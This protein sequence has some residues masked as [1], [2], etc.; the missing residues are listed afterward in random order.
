[1]VAVKYAMVDR[2][3]LA[4]R[5]LWVLAAGD[6]AAFVLFATLGHA[7]HGESTG[8]GHIVGTA[9]P[10]MVGWLVM[11]PWAGAYRLPSRL[12]LRQLLQCTG[13]AWLCAWPV[14]LLLRALILQRGIPLSFAL[15]ALI[16]NAVFLCIWRTAFVL[17]LSRKG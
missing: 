1:M 3:T 6:A 9:V 16:A 11:A 8:I 10:F 13:F 14:A 5:R 4:D 12:Q 17:A 2:Q 15:V 7:Q